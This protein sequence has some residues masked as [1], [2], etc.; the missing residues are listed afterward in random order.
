MFADGDGCSHALLISKQR[1]GPTFSNT[2]Q[3]IYNATIRTCSQINVFC[4]C[5]KCNT[6][7]RNRVR[8]VCTSTF[9]IVDLSKRWNSFR[10]TENKFSNV[11]RTFVFVLFQHLLNKLTKETMHCLSLHGFTTAHIKTDRRSK[12]N[13]PVYHRN[14]CYILNYN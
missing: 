12:Q 6:I 11:Q 4:K 13:A 3:T 9:Q 1:V 14:V 5:N 7:F 2:D 10:L 8:Q